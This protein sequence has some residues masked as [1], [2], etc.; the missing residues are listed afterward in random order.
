MH[1]RCCHRSSWVRVSFAYYLPYVADGILHKRLLGAI[2]KK[3]GLVRTH[4]AL[5]Y[6]S[7]LLQVASGVFSIIAFYRFRHNDEAKQ[8]CI[9]GS[10][11]Q[12]RINV[13]NALD[14]RNTPEWAIWVSSLVPI[15]VVACMSPC[16]LLM[17][18][19]FSYRFQF[20]RRCLLCR[21]QLF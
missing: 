17:P 8:R 3:N 20:I 19:T 21:A 6:V 2:F 7:L 14:F 15:V 16:F 9:A 18:S 12:T 11:D 1:F 4:L 13:C 10:N 5:L